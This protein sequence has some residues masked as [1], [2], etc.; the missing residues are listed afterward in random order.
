MR[1]S[2][3]FLII[4]GIFI[5][6]SS[7][8]SD[9]DS[10]PIVQDIDKDLVSLLKSQSPTSSV[11]YFYFLIQKIIIRYLRT[12]KS[13]YQSQS[14]P[15]KFLF[16]E[17]GLSSDAK[18]PRMAGTFSCASCHHASAGFQAGTLQGIGEGGF[19]FGRKGESRRPK[20]DIADHD[21]QPIRSPSAMNGAYQK[22]NCGTD[23]LVP[24]P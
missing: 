3:H 16:H 4:F 15:W 9:N 20:T 13:Y 18:D 21:V 2:M 6:L 14:N 17:T 11:D 12:P 1:T 8:S 19:G 5:L 24:P 23:N 22:I 7:C 10:N